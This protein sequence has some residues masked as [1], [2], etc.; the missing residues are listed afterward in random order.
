MYALKKRLFL[1]KLLLCKNGLKPF[2]YSKRAAFYP[3]SHFII[4]S[5][6]SSL[7]NRFRV[8]ESNFLNQAA[9]FY[10][11]NLFYFLFLLK[12]ETIP[13]RFLGI[14]KARLFKRQTPLHYRKFQNC[15]IFY[16]KIS[17]IRL[18]YD[19]SKSIMR[20]KI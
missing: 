12:K 15:I 9:F 17:F 10:Q 20:R 3:F 7:V 2:T 18:T 13:F 4:I 1:S 14:K 5:V 6:F 19:F 16:K 11:K 8:C